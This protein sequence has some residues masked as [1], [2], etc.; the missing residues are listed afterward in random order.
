MIP[1]IRRAKVPL[2]GERLYAW[3]LGAPYH[4]LHGSPVDGWDGPYSR[5]DRKAQQEM[6]G[7]DWGVHGREDLVTRLNNLGND[8]HRRGHRE[9]V[10]RFSTT[11]R[12][13][14]AAAREAWRGT[15]REGGEDAGEAARDLW[16]LDV[17]QADVRG[18]RSAPL[19]AFDAARGIMLARDGL[20]LGW[21]SEDEAF[22]YMLDVARDAGRTYGSWA[23]FGADY[24][25]S[26]SVWAG[27]FESDAFDHAVE[28]LL[29]DKASP[30]VSTPWAQPGLA[31]PRPVR[32]W[33]AG[34]PVW[35]LERG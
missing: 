28:R 1:S 4:L 33:N 13:N 25:L 2:S 11:W 5:S 26:R 14:V 12:P 3:A 6:L 15:I 24:L 22:D 32:P 18:V 27:T 20:L 9:Q 16:L 31:V 17:V 8:G 29:R 34:V 10:N 19:L 21:L 23:E 30:W 7:R 35:T